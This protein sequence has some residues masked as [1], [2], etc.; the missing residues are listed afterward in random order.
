MRLRIRENDLRYQPFSDLKA[1]AELRGAE[2][3]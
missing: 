1:D 3:S 2:R